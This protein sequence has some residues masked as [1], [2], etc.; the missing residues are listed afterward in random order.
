MGPSVGETEC[1]E[2]H[3]WNRSTKSWEYWPNKTNTFWSEY[4]LNNATEAPPGVYWI[5][6][7]VAYSFLPSNWREACTLGVINPS[8]FMLPLNI[9]HVLSADQWQSRKLKADYKI[10]DWKDDEWPSE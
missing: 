9:P 2:V 3:E 10:G 4:S 5:C 8:F 6:G 7:D 1:M